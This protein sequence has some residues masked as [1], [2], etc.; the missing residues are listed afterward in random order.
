MKRVY[1]DTSAFI[2]LFVE[3]QDGETVQG[4]A[5]LA[6]QNKITI[7]LSDWVLNESVG[8]VAKKFRKGLV[9]R[10]E[11]SEIL[12]NIADMLEGVIERWNIESY[13]ITED[14][15]IGS[16]IIIQDVYPHASDALHLFVA[17]VTKCDY[18]VTADRKLA[19]AIRDSV[20]RLMPIN[21][22]EPD[23]IKLFL[24]DVDSK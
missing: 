23:D 3:E 15:I 13:S 17:I 5:S 18:F 1:L 21:I 22:Q 9:D 16:R 11:A 6:N 14:V 8:V 2:K 12:T 20:P 10:K 24:D 4:I 19:L 7:V